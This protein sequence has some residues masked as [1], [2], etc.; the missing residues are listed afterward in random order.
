[1]KKK[2]LSARQRSVSGVRFRFIGFFMRPAKAFI[3]SFRAI[4][5]E[6]DGGEKTR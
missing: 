1:L 2:G 6:V 4:L 5:P 3:E